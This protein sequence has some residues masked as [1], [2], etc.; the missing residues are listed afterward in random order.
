MCRAERA[1]QAGCF[2]LTGCNHM[3][4][5]VQ[6][7]KRLILPSSKNVSPDPLALI[8]S[9]YGQPTGQVC[10]CSGRRRMHCLY[11]SQA[12]QSHVICPKYP[13]TYTWSLSHQKC[14]CQ[15]ARQ[16][17]SPEC[18]QQN[19]LFHQKG[20]MAAAVLW[21]ADN[22]AASAFVDLYSWASPLCG[23]VWRA[24]CIRGSPP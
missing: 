8:G 1:G 15:G 12:K 18:T 23:W 17:E 19:A 9:S 16:R 24:G 13:V 10:F 2:L 20:N 7:A 5:W 6:F 11:T 3:S 21:I 4:A 22:L 14:L